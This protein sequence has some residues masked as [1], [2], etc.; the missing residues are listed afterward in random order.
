MDNKTNQELFKQ[1]LVEGVNRRLDRE[2]AAC[3]EEIAY[4][5][6]HIKAM[7]RIVNGKTP[8][9]PLSTK[10]IAI[11]VAAAILLL[12]GCAII[13]RNEIRDFITDV[14]E[15]FV[16][17]TF[18]AGESESRVIEEVY[19]LTYIPDGYEIESEYIYKYM[20]QIVIRDS[21][22]DKIKFTQRPL[23]NSSFMV[24]V[25][26]G[27]DEIFSVGDY[28][29][30]YQEADGINCYIWNDGKY[31]FKLNSTEELSLQMLKQII[32]GIKTK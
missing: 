17:V 29:I 32:N 26:H 1:A 30:Y 18:D 25:E 8:R 14:Q 20:V 13:Y 6:R 15:F 28:R 3:D 21:R 11:L 12:A 27:Y 23:D 4:S 16:K 22:G 31:A 2:I 24:D 10:M 5:R 19:E 9:K 7:T